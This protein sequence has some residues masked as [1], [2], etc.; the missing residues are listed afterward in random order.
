MSQGSCAGAQDLAA[1]K[2][3]LRVHQAPANVFYSAYPEASVL[4]LRDDLEFARE[5]GPIARRL[6]GNPGLD[7]T[8]RAA[9]R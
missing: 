4:N 1:L 9:T 8:G 3:F 2:Q 6:A 7:T 5:S